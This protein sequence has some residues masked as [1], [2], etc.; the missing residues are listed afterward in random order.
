MKNIQYQCVIDEKSLGKFD[1]I[2]P[3]FSSLVASINKETQKQ[4]LMFWH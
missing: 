3:I 4:Y 1:K 2:F